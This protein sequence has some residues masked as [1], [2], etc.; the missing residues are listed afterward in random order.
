VLPADQ[1]PIGRTPRR[2]PAR[3]LGV[4][5]ALRRVFAGTPEA[6]ARGFGP[7][8]FSFNST[9]GGRCQTCAGQGAISHEMSF[10]PDVTTPCEACGG[11]RFEPSTL[12]I[13]WR[14]LNVGETLRLT[15]DEALEA[16]SALP[17][18]AGPLR[19]LSELGVGYLQLG[20][21]RHTLAGG[22]GQRPEL[23]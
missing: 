12:E 23:A 17:R 11:A 5:D 9:V 21:G 2:V 16:F 6:R 18:G 3:F 20:Q 7:G 14:G 10:L 22:G 4:R 1:T 15:V 19:C 13:R 8:R